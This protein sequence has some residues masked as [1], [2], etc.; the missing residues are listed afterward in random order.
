MRYSNPPTLTLDHDSALKA[1]RGEFARLLL[2]VVGIVLA[3]L[4]VFDRLA[5]WAAPRLPFAWEVKIARSTGLDELPLKVMGQGK[6]TVSAQQRQAIEADLQRRLDRIAQ[7]VELSPEIRITAH[8]IDSPT[9]NAVATLGGHVSVFS[10][11]LRK[12]E[13]EEELDAVL[14]HELGHVQH[15]HIVRQ[16]SRGIG[17]AVA[18]SLLGVNSQALNRWLLGDAQQLTQLAYSRQ[19]EYEADATAA[20]AVQKLH[21]H[22]GGLLRLFERFE[23]LHTERGGLAGSEWAAMLQTHPH[24]AERI[25]AIHTA[26]ANPQRPMLTPLSG[27]LKIEPAPR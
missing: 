21:G 27:V 25:R 1:E 17:T 12:I 18:L 16:L 26:F 3:V 6:Q 19:A 5:Y 8:F 20:Q 9:I 14:A 4:F 24:P 11:L 13:Y 2:I 22:T 15:R 23:A 10:G 7:A